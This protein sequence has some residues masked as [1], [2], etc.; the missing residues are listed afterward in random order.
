MTATP[1]QGLNKQH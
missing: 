1:F